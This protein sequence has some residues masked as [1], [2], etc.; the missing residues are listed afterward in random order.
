M[1]L[2]TQ[3]ALRAGVISRCVERGL[4]YT[5]P[6]PLM[7]LETVANWLILVRCEC[8]LVIGAIVYSEI[9]SICKCNLYHKAR[10]KGQKKTLLANLFLQK[11]LFYC[12]REPVNV[13]N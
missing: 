8:Y 12:D 5:P 1:I 13:R 7:C 11:G 2:A 4:H 9:D 6:L 3:A 10:N